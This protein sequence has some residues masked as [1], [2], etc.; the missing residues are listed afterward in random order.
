MTLA[1]VVATALIAT[2]I[3]VTAASY[4]SQALREL[5]NT[6]DITGTGRAAWVARF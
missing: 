1:Y 4:V 3:L 6:G 5:I 2:A